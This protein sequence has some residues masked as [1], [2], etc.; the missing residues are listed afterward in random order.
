[1]AEARRE[2]G[3]A[4]WRLADLVRA[5]ERR[6]S[7]RAKAYRRAV[8]SLDDLSPDLSDPPETILSTPG[9][10][11]G[12][13]RLIIEFEETG[14][15]DLLDRLQQLYP[16]DVSTMRRLPRMTPSILRLLKGELGVETTEQLRGAIESGAVE[17]LRGVGPG[18]AER[19]DRA[20]ALAPAPG[21]LPAFQAW[22]LAETLAR[23]LHRHLGVVAEPAGQVRTMEEWVEVVELV[24]AVSDPPA[25]REFLQSTAVARFLG[26][27]ETGEVILRSHEDVEVR[28]H[29]VSPDQAAP[30]L[31]MITGPPG[32]ARAILDA[33]GGVTTSESDI[34]AASG[35]IWIPPP[36]RGLPDEVAAEVIRLGHVRGDLHLHS[37]LSPDGRMSLDEIL[38]EAVDRGYEYV[39]ITDH[40]SGLR[41]GGLTEAGLEDQAAAIEEVRPRFPDLVVLQ[42]AELNITRDGD[43]DI[44]D[45]TLSRLDLAV[46]GLHSFFDLTRDEQTA[47]IV[48]ALSHPVVRV[49]AHPTGRRIGAR[50]AV[51]LDIEAV[52]A[53]AIDHDA[54]LEVNGHRDRLDL[55][56]T[57]AALAV[58][59]GALLAADSDAHRVGEMGNIANSVATMQRA[60]VSPESVVNT[61]SATRFM[62]WVR[63]GAP[64][65]VS[66]QPE[67]GS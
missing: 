36:A 10:G 20:L 14:S 31:L 15:L 26:F 17:A 53:A 51:E 11:A 9:I 65:G 64:A 47:R 48:R 63:G 22:V 1:M 19:W 60:G 44:G 34:Y 13:L 49:L 62:A 24:A 54:A 32:H 37:D 52:I 67:T 8:W 46:A 42:G 50:P 57:H 18:T 40:T 7:F 6:R 25:G 3:A 27:G 4:L 66:R 29:L 38:I 28:A 43:L 58:S 16:T 41:F 56:A 55:S 59:A 35:R 61:W 2:L 39:L 12:V 5:D 30:R 33:A 23:H 45:E 21:V